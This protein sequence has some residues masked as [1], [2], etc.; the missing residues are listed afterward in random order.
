PPA[1]APPP[2]LTP[3]ESARR[4][5][6]I[7][8][9]KEKLNDDANRH[10]DLRDRLNDE[11]KKH[12]QRRDELNGQVRGLIDRANQHRQRRDELNVQVREAKVKRDE[13]NK[14]A[15]EKA[16]ALN[17]LKRDRLPRGDGVPLSKLKAQLKKL[18]YDHMTKALT[19]AKEKALMEEMSALQKQ[20]N[21]KEKSYEK[22]NTVKA[23]YE[24]MKTAKEAAEKQHR[25]V[26]ELA[27][28]AQEQHDSMVKL[29]EEADGI[30][31]LADAAQEQFVKAKTEADKIHNEYIAM[32]NQIRDY[33]KQIIGLR[34]DA[35]KVRQERGEVEAKAA[36][37]TIMDK[38]KKGGK[39]STEDLLILQKSGEGE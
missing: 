4:I 3:Q 37:D 8:D 39:L 19:P 33:E 22:D 29:F 27:N 21:E 11:T 34:A 38:L 28:A 5:E 6:M 30:R 2:I 25:H 31:K 35:K 36:A 24:E 13:L 18:E 9:R 1:E 7:H 15:N 12:A 23:A 26:T 17:A 20:I 14:V 10:R 16:E 32:V